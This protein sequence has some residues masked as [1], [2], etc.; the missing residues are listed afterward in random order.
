MPP[1]NTDGKVARA[2]FE[3][4]RPLDDAGHDA[5]SD[6][7]VKGAGHAADSDAVVAVAESLAA[8]ITVLVLGEPSASAP[9]A[10]NALSE[11]D[12]A[13]ADEARAPTW[14]AGPSLETPAAVKANEPGV[15]PSSTSP[16]RSLAHETE[17]ARAF[18]CAPVTEP[19]AAPIAVPAPEEVPAPDQSMLKNT[20]ITPFT[21]ATTTTFPRAPTKPPAPAPIPSPCSGVVLAAPSLTPSREL[22]DELDA[23]SGVE[24]LPL[25]LPSSIDKAPTP[26]QGEQ[27]RLDE[28]PAAKKLAA[29]PSEAP[30]AQPSETPAAQSAE[31]S[32]TQPVKTPKAQSVNQLTAQPAV[33]SAVQ[34][35][36]QSTAQPAV[37]PAEM[38]AARPVGV[39]A[40][41]RR[42]FKAPRIEGPAQIALAGRKRA[43]STLDN[44]A[45]GN[46]VTAI[47]QSDSEAVPMP[48]IK[49]RT[50]G[51]L[52]KVDSETAGQLRA[53]A[54]QVAQAAQ[55]RAE[56]AAASAAAAALAPSSSSS[57]SCSS[58]LANRDGDI[59]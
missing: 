18:A 40:S 44:E 56:K 31:V 22:M 36:M 33:Q 39:L 51:A 3:Q 5:D 19:D 47:E 1:D 10:P 4:P 58:P 54:Q 49:V 50:L 28:A 42:P 43:I 25:D 11:L 12:V 48:K 9:T 26:P 35:A 29:Q 32:A 23:V 27:E 24:V 34:S 2:F 59:S 53:A 52:R 15:G 16:E 6:D 41:L 21:S 38:S 7:L 37:Q 17:P 30:A 20:A 8:D 45:G 13:F 55:A 46:N 57:S 14:G